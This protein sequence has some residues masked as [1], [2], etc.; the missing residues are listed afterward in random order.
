MSNQAPLYNSRVIQVFLEYIR[1]HHPKVEIDAVL[2]YAGI[3]N[4]Q[5]DDPGVWFNQNQVD[6]FNEILVEKTGQIDIARKAGRFTAFSIGMGALKQY[7][8]SLLNTNSI[9]M[10]IAKAYRTL[11]LGATAKTK[12]IGTNA[13]EII[14]TPNLGVDEKSYQCKNRIGIFESLSKFYT[15]DYAK[16][17]H[18][19]CYH[20]GDDSCRYIITW[21]H[22]TYITLKRFRNYSLLLGVFSTLTFFFYMPALIWLSISLMIAFGIIIMS[23]L[24]EHSGNNRFSKAIEYQGEAA[25]NLIEEIKVRHSHSQLVQE[26]GQATAANSSV[27]SLATNMLAIIKRHLDFSRGMILLTDQRSK[28]LRYT[29]GFGFKDTE[30]EVIKQTEF[31]QGRNANVEILGPVFSN[32]KPYLSNNFGEN[33]DTISEQTMALFKQINTKCFI[34]LPIV[35]QGESIGFLYVDNIEPQR[36]LTQSELSLLTGVA[37]QAAISI[38]N[39]HSFEEL[40]KSEA[41]LK[42]LND[43]LEMRVVERTAELVS[44][45]KDLRASLKEKDVLLKEVHHRVKNNLQIVS[46]LIDMTRRRSTNQE[47]YD[48]LSEAHA[49]ILTMSLIHSQLYRSNRVNQINIGIHLR[50]LFNHLAQ[51]YG[52]GKYITPLLVAEGIHL[53][54]TQAIP[55]AFVLNELI[56]NAYKYAFEEGAEGK[57]EVTITELPEDE[58]ISIKVKDNGV[59]IPEEIDVEKTNSLG[60]KLVRNLVTKQLK[61]S[62]NIFRNQGTE[63]NIEF[64]PRRETT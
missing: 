43:E 49:K 11:S 61:G 17:E 42:K 22:S 64:A 19:T 33:D 57:I 41:A 50:E 58:V 20:Q 14:V 25:E 7:V 45:E 51:L 2:Q 60:M 10:I 39:I 8:L 48:L 16:V 32:Q 38:K 35:F 23:L 29:T 59:G 9:Y 31:S 62:L 47:T 36:R 63:I 30:V 1:K 37:S 21:K 52:K 12:K 44:S 15:N 6:K 5:V 27:D 13:V 55:C 56:S 4:Y 40:Q 34:C 28:C 53:P 18:P 46:S 54:V 26:M 3:T 24:V